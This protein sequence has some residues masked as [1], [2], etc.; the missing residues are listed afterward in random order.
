[1]DKEDIDEIVKQVGY[2]PTEIPLPK[3]VKEKK[4][5]SKKSRSKGKQKKQSKSKDKDRDRK[6]RKAP[7]EKKTNGLPRPTYDGLSGGKEGKKGK[8]PS[9]SSGEGAFGWIKKLFN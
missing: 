5:R 2:A 3:E 4:S 7:K 6:R 8:R 9:P 1:M